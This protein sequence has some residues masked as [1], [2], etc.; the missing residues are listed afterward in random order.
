MEE[1]LLVAEVAIFVYMLERDV[2]LGQDAADE[3]AAVAVLGF[4]FAAEEGDANIF[5]PG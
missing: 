1:G 3:A 2:A 5:L 4:A